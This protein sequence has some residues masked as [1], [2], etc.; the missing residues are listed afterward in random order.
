[1]ARLLPGSEVQ[2]TYDDNFRT[3]RP[4]EPHEYFGSVAKVDGPNVFIDFGEEGVFRFERSNTLDVAGS[5]NLTDV[6]GYNIRIALQQ[7]QLMRV[8][9]RSL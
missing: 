3:D 4:E 7:Q 1:M 9:H 8:H 6:D 5:I 2:C